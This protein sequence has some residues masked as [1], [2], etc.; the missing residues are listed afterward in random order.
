MLLTTLMLRSFLLWQGNHLTWNFVPY[1]QAKHRIIA[2]NPEIAQ[3]LT[4]MDEIA[5]S[6]RGASATSTTRIV[7]VY[8][9]QVPM[10]ATACFC[11]VIGQAKWGWNYFRSSKKSQIQFYEIMDDDKFDLATNSFLKKKFS[12]GGEGQG[13]HMSYWKKWPKCSPAHLVDKKVM[14]NL[15]RGK[16][17]PKNVRYVLL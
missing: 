16:K 5:F 11:S 17:K 3:R 2:L 14:R 15:N 4:D 1:G 9:H 13:D 6:E 7:N 8:L 10:Y 12:W